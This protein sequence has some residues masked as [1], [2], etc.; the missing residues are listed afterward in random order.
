MTG[1]VEAGD[2]VAR[3]AAPT[4]LRFSRRSRLAHWTL[5]LPFLLLLAT[6]LLLFVPEIKGVHVGGYRL[7]PL[8]HVLAGIALTVALLP[9]FLL[10]PG[11]RRLHADLRRLFHWDNTDLT[12]LRYA[13]YVLLGAR[14][15]QPPTGKF[16]AG[17]KANAAASLVFSLGLIVTGAILAV[18]FFTKSVFD[19]R[20]VEKVY[21][22]HDLFMLVSIPIVAGHI[23]FAAINPGTRSALRGMLDGRVDL[24]WARGHHQRWVAEVEA[25]TL[26]QTAA[27]AAHAA[28]GSAGPAQRG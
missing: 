28:E 4:I 19:A 18:N 5:A 12:W 25:E 15:R 2:S 6:G 11:V 3:P 22:Y 27:P 17:Q 20:F 1:T 23:Y 24:A 7:V 9:V 26:S 8:I 14:L 21:P 13:A 16:N 10:Q